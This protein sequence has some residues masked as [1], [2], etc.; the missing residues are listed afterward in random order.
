MFDISVSSRL[1]LAGIFLA[2]PL[3]FVL[4]YR[5]LKQG[6]SR[7]FAAGV[8]LGV[9]GLVFALFSMWLLTATLNSGWGGLIFL[10][11]AGVELIAALVGAILLLAFWVRRGAA[12]SRVPEGAACDRE[13]PTA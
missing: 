6:R 2:G 12:D 5:A 8:G 3:L 4:I 11:G 10:F 9:M 13:E 7:L 1:L